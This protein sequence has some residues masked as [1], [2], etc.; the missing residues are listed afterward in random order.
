MKS[1]NR[2][3]KILNFL[4]LISSDNKDAC[5]QLYNDNKDRFLESKGSM[6]KHQSWIGGYIDHLVETMEFGLDLYNSM[7]I[8]R[9]LP[10]T[11][12]DVIIVLFLHDLE[13]PF[14]YVE[15][16]LEFGSDIDKLNFIINKSNEYKIKLSEMHI[17][18]L[19]YIHGENDD[20]NFK[21]VQK[22][23]AAFVHICDVVSARIWFDYP[24]NNNNE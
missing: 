23:L 21:R 18:G 10:F 8:K 16:V 12:S 13:K 22:P 24:K 5:I 14:K 2:D 9:E 11:I 3:T 15:P 6:S 17:N 20:Y 7:S 4:S 19:K 1:L